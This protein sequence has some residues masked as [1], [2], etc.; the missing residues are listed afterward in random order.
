MSSDPSPSVVVPFAPP[1]LSLHERRILGVLVEKQKTTP[2]VYP[3]SINA[4]AT[5]CNQKSNRDPV[6]EMSEDDV[7]DA[8]I[9][10]QKRG[11]VI[12]ITGGRVERWRHTLYDTWHVDKVEMAVL[13]ELLLRGAQSEGELRGR[14]SRMEPIEDLDKLRA[15]CKPLAERK[16]VIYLTPEGRRG[17]TLTHGFQ[18]VRDL[19]RLRAMHGSAAD[20]PSAP[21]ARESRPA[22]ERPASRDSRLD[23]ALAQIAA[24]Q[25]ALTDLRG[26]VQALTSRLERIEDR[27]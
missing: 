18:D 19:D 5:G 1:I 14:V 23:D 15:V 4:L 6:L 27:G 13:A 26:E 11:L 9:S 2:D 10:C 7:E 17:T 8:L 20:E 25:A 16:L 24:L 21:P 22:E 12:K 3:L